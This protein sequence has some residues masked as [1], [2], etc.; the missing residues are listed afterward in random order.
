M[1]YNQREAAPSWTQVVLRPQNTG[2]LPTLRGALGR[3]AGLSAVGVGVRCSGP[4]VVL[5]PGG[6]GV[7]PRSTGLQTL[8]TQLSR[9]ITAGRVSEV[10]SVRGAVCCGPGCVVRQRHI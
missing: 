9:S 2:R 10:L 7:R 1:L 8:E 6:A 5:I 3:P 4:S